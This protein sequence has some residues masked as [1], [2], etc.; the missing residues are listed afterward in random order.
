MKFYYK[1]ILGLHNASVCVCCGKDWRGWISQEEKEKF[2]TI[3]FPRIGSKCWFQP[4][5]YKWKILT[6]IFTFTTFHHI[7]PH[8]RWQSMIIQL[9]S[10]LFRQT[11][12][13]D[14]SSLFCVKT[15]NIIFVVLSLTDK[16]SENVWLFWLNR[17]PLNAYVLYYWENWT[18]LLLQIFVK[19][20][21]IMIYFY[22]KFIFARF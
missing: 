10:Q 21:F 16:F 18:E 6:G 5:H 17:S 7:S 3:C 8:F 9:V 14:F 4:N 2:E 13:R 12:K 20:I 19:T 11:S 1:H 15:A 22:F